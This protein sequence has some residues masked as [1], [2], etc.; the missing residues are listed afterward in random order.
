MV[1]LRHRR[2]CNNFSKRALCRNGWSGAQFEPSPKHSRRPG[3]RHDKI[4]LGAAVPITTDSDS[5]TADAAHQCN[6]G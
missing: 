3:I 4:P 5:A 1:V 2:G 6:V